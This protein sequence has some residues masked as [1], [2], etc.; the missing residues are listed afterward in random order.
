MSFEEFQDGHHGGHQGYLNGRI[1]AILN[2]CVNVMLPIKFWLNQ[3]YGLEGDVI[4]RIS[5]GRPWRLSW[6]SE[7]YNFSNSEFLCCSNASHQVLAQSHLQFGRRCRLKYGGHGNRTILAILSLY[8]S[9]KPPINLTYCLGLDEVGRTGYL[10]GTILAILNLCVIVMLPIRFW[11][12]PTFG[13]GDVVWHISRWPPW[14][15]SW[16]LDRNNLSNS[17][18][19]CHSVASHKVSAQ[20]DLWFWRRYRL[21]NFKMATMV[22]ILDIGNGTILAILNL[23]VTVMLPIKFWLN[24]TYSLGGDIV[25][26]ISRWPPW[27]SEQN[28]LSNSESLCCSDASHKVSAQSDLW[29]WR[30]YH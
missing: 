22:A 19:L 16:K 3:T 26:R 30:K 9:P 28:N 24:P 1:L 2:L 25:W 7:G 15:P 5:R 8:N 14:R 21:K 17:E 20:S 18:S 12:N 11:L 6:I 29:F 27:L 4:W 23:C 10:N 13:L